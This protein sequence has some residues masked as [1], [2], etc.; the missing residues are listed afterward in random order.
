MITTCRRP[1]RRRARHSLD[2]RRDIP[3]VIDHMPFPVPESPEVLV[4]YKGIGLFSHDRGFAD[5]RRKR[6]GSC[7]RLHILGCDIVRVGSRQ[8]IVFSLWQPV[9]SR[10]KVGSF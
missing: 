7:D 4:A 2:K 3:G 10:A 5:D 8:T 6:A 1:E 9:P